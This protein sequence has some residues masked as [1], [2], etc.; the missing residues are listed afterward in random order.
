M[1][2][3]LLFGVTFHVG[4]SR[5]PRRPA[6]VQCT[7]LQIC[8]IF[9]ILSVGEDIILPPFI[10]NSLRFARAVGDACPYGFVRR[11]M[12]LLVGGGTSVLL[13]SS[14]APTPTDLCEI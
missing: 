3:A 4:R 11:L 2:L 14:R 6:D 10:K 9:D 7:P 8:T 1:V 5:R 13:G 12:F